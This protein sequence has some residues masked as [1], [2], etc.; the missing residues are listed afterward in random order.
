[1]KNFLLVVLFVL[2][3]VGCGT[4]CLLLRMP[5]SGFSAM[6]VE[7]LAVREGPAADSTQA[8]PVNE[9]SPVKKAE[10]K[11]RTTPPAA[12]DDRGWKGLSSD[13][14]YAGKQLSERDFNG[15]VALVYVWSSKEKP[16]VALLSRIEE[17]W[18]SFKDKPFVVVG[19]HRGG[20]NPKIP[21]AC[22]KLGLTFPMY[23]GAAFGKE[24]T[25]SHYPYLYVV[26]HHGKVVY[27]GTSD[28]SATEA[29]VNAVTACVL[30]Q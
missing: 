11:S 17:I 15:K 14:W 26:N 16:S 3:V 25:V 28:R 7:H 22:Q 19:S 6:I 1:M 13:D 29:V 23:E 24:P 10:P 18:T 12:S 20:R 9:P 30:K 4:S 8:S 27:R 21:N 2:A 5:R